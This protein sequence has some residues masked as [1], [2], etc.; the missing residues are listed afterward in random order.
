MERGWI[1]SNAFCLSIEIYSFFL[2]IWY[3]SLIDFQIFNQSCISGI[4]PI[5][6]GCIIFFYYVAGFSL[7]LYY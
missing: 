3:I 6:S 5:W 2:L 1:L 7:L 4:Y